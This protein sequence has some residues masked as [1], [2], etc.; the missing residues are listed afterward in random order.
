MIYIIKIFINLV[1]CHNIPLENMA[2][3]KELVFGHKISRKMNMNCRINSLDRIQ[4]MKS[5]G[6]NVVGLEIGYSSLKVVAGN[7]EGR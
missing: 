6:L 4:S 3:L 5:K 2:A 1:C 7:S